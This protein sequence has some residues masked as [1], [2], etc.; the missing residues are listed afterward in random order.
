MKAW[1]HSLACAA[2]VLFLAAPASA[3]LKDVTGQLAIASGHGAPTDTTSPD[4]SLYTDV[5]T[6]RTYTSTTGA[7]T[8]VTHTAS[9]A[10]TL[11]SS[12]T[13]TLIPATQFART[14][15]IVVNVTTSFANG[16]GA[17]P[18]FAIGQTSSTSKFA[19]TSAFTSKTAGTT[20]TYGG[21]LSAGTALLVTA[22]AGTGTT[23]TGAMTVTAIATP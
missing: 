8:P 9:T 17:Q 3:Q 12:G 5:D 21:T 18:T 6:G 22:T 13:T 11:A 23:E 14:V 16:D 15:L 7:W 10:F 20:L 4:G 1:I 19:A 2:V